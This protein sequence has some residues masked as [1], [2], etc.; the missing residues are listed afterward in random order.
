MAPAIVETM[1][2]HERDGTGDAGRAVRLLARSSPPRLI[3]DLGSAQQREAL[4]PAL[5]S[6]ERIAV[7]AHFEPGAR[8]DLRRVTT[9]ARR[10]GGSW[11]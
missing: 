6:G 2:T 9:A 8:Y 11:A 5:S 10:S 7:L 3:R 1:L 4:L